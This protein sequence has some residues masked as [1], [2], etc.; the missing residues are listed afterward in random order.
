MYQSTRSLNPFLLSNGADL[1][2]DL[3]EQAP[4]G[5]LVMDP[6]GSI[7]YANRHFSLMTGYPGE[8]LVSHR[9]GDLIPDEPS[10]EGLSRLFASLVD[11]VCAE[12]HQVLLSA[13]ECRDGGEIT[14]EIKLSRLGAGKPPFVMA[15]VQD[16]TEQKRQQYL[17]YVLARHDD[18]TGLPNR[19][20]LSELLATRFPVSA[21][22][23]LLL[24][25]LDHFRQVN[26]S[27]GHEFGDL[28]LV[29]VCA[30][31]VECLPAD[32]VLVRFSGDVLVVL[33]GD[34][35]R[36]RVIDVAESVLAAMKKPILINDW[37]YR[38]SLSLGIALIPADGQDVS[39]LVKK[40]DLALGWAK[41]AGGATYSFYDGPVAQRV[42][43]RHRLNV[44]LRQALERGEFHLHYQPR[45]DIRTGHVTG[46]EALLRWNQPT[47]GNI[48]P[49]EFIPVAEESGL[50]LEIGDWVLRQAVA[51][52]ASWIGQGL[53]PGTMAVNLS[54]RQFRMPNLSRQIA[55]ILALHAV[56]PESLELEITE[57]ALME[58]VS[59]AREIL[60]EI[61]RMGVK[62]A[63]DDF[64]TGHS[65]L[66]YLRDF[67]FDRLKIDRS[68]V[69]CLGHDSQ[70]EAIAQA[71]IV[72]AHALNL[73][74]VAEGV[75]TESQLQYLGANQCDEIQGFL[76]SRP[77][78]PAECER[79]LR[80]RQDI[81]TMPHTRASCR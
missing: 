30:R 71:I 1:P 47:E 26:E 5:V 7:L 10:R 19:M 38:Q 45:L 9:L 33:L 57:T 55:E 31:L 3:I 42:Q 76:F 48:S 72:L 29:A 51:Q 63:I 62:L 15:F 77:L 24:L 58:D 14:V 54:P 78:P 4:E 61:S 20:Q 34:A 17:L 25:D 80:D 40:A 67:P 68:F 53:C 59:S 79:L 41:A 70:Q 64:G 6:A 16:V 27:L 36:T 11:D 37:K 73:S 35:D 60:S 22:G 8:T 49:A 18:L 74:V 2:S 81:A 52:Q 50:I 12:T 23:A 13:L 69:I 44:L 46:W 65:S 75:E 43:R 28:L 39:Q 21:Q 32:S 56:E 66:N